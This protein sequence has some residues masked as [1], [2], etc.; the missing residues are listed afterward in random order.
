MTLWPR[1]FS[2]LYSS[3]SMKW[4]NLSD[5]KEEFNSFTL[6]KSSALGVRIENCKQDRGRRKRRR[7][8]RRRRRIRRRRRRRRRRRHKQPAALCWRR[9]TSFQCSRASW[10]RKPAETKTCLG[11]VVAG[12]LLCVSLRH[13][14][15]ERLARCT[16]GEPTPE[17]TRGVAL[18]WWRR[19]HESGVQ[20]MVF[21]GPLRASVRGART[22]TAPEK[23]PVENDHSKKP[24]E[25]RLVCWLWKG[26][27]GS[28]VLY[29]GSTTWDWDTVAKE[30]NFFNNKLALGQANSK[31]TTQ[32]LSL[33]H[34]KP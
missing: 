3:T 15:R 29:Q 18:H 27:N 33:W 4:T 32:N 12:Q 5:F 11:V 8:R 24:L 9:S 31:T 10:R 1:N 20:R 6:L 19:S 25:A 14:R 30:V 2:S 23:L 34:E 21:P 17:Q 7:R 16:E 13:L 22:W 26:G 28:R